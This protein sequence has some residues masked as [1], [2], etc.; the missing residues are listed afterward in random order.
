MNYEFVAYEGQYYL[1]A[2]V[3]VI[4]LRGAPFFSPRPI[5]F[6]VCSLDRATYKTAAEVA[7]KISELC[8][9]PFHRELGQSF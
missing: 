3:L 1:R 2:N 8:I 6:L 7:L 9:G 4:L 5:D